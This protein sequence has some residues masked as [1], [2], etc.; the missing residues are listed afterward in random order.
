MT[1]L[2]L[3]LLYCC[4]FVLTDAKKHLY[5]LPVAFVPMDTMFYWPSP[6]FLVGQAPLAALEVLPWTPVLWWVFWPYTTCPFQQA[7]YPQPPFLLLSSARR[8]Q[9]FPFHQYGLSLILGT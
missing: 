5:W 1:A 2:D 4:H 8:T 3:F 6:Q 7:H 9:A